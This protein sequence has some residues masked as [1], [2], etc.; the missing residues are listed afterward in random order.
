MF[1]VNILGYK[2]TW[3]NNNIDVLAYC[4]TRRKR[5]TTKYEIV[6]NPILKWFDDQALACT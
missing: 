2:Y 1:R 6:Y 5:K 4:K 3:Q